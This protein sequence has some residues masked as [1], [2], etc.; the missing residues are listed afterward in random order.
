MFVA[1]GILCLIL[2]TQIDIDMKTLAKYPF[3]CYFI[4][5]ILSAVIAS[6]NVQE[7]L[8]A[9]PI[10]VCPLLFAAAAWAS[11]GGGKFSE[12]GKNALAWYGWST[13]FGLIV[14]LVMVWAI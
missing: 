10:I 8:P 6:T 11:G 4:A 7:S 1:L 13:L 2:N 5:L 9:V 3:L 12:A 14:G